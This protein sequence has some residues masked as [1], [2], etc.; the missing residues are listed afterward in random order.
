MQVYLM[1]L[2]TGEGAWLI[3]PIKNKSLIKDFI[4]K[5]GISTPTDEEFIIADFD[6]EDELDLRLGEFDD[7]YSINELLNHYEMLDEYE[8]HKVL[9]LIET[10][11]NYISDF[12][13]ALSTYEDFSLLEDIHTQYELG[14][15]IIADALYDLKDKLP[16]YL[17]YYIDFEAVGRD[18][19]YSGDVF[20]TTYGALY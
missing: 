9:A 17:P 14:E 8:K 18:S 7:V 11:G 1:N 3:L 19:V 16:S 5:H 10:N 13:N 12:D 15:Y 6:C 2:G 4:H 20:L